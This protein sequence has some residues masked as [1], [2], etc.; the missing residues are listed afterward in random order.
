MSGPA[1]SHDSTTWGAPTR[2]IRTVDDVERLVRRFYQLAIPDPLVGRVFHDFGIDW[3]EH[4]PKLVEFWSARLLGVPGYAGN[5][6]GAHQPVLERCGFGRAELERWLE[7]WGET[8]DELVAGETAELAKA[9]A[10]MAGQAIASLVRRHE[11][12]R[13]SLQLCDGRG[14]H[15]G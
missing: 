9:R 1:R 6:V 3:S 12:L 11:R 4:I 7:L 8:V 15:H 14:P 13:P 2:D 5:A 10:A